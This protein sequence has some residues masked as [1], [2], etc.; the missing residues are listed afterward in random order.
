[1][2]NQIRE[3]LNERFKVLPKDTNT[4]KL[5]RT[6]IDHLSKQYDLA[7]KGG[8]DA[9][10]VTEN[11]NLTIEHYGEALQMIKEADLALLE[12]EGQT[13]HKILRTIFRS[14][15]LWVVVFSFYFIVSVAFNL[16]IFSWMIF[17]FGAVFQC[18]I[19]FKLFAP[20]L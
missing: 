5:K 10:T 18:Y 2:K 3:Q 17:L 13:S 9:A 16:W 12:Q 1:M 8:G 14:I 11:I 6:M 20:R 7:M 19:I 4:L 15:F